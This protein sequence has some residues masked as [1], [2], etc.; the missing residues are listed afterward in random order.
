MDFLGVGDAVPTHLRGRIKRL[1]DAII[2]NNNRGIA[3]W[4]LNKF[5]ERSGDLDVSD[6][7]ALAK[8]LNTAAKNYKA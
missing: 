4:N 1:D 2:A 8:I 7:D 3:S 5:L 6:P